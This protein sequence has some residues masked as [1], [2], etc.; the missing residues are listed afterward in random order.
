MEVVPSSSTTQQASTSVAE[1]DAAITLASLQQT[2][3]D[4]TFAPKFTSNVWT[5][6]LSKG[7]KCVHMLCNCYHCLLHSPE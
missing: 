5:S 4:Q 1:T 6:G 2:P 3:I 7:K